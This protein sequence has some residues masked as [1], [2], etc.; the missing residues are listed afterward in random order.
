MVTSESQSRTRQTFP[1]GHAV[2]YTYDPADR[3]LQ[4]RDWDSLV[5]A[6]SYD[7]GNWLTQ[8]ALPNGVVSIYT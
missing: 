8:T 1:D 2:Q 3:M 5:T 6:Y 7:P 4:V